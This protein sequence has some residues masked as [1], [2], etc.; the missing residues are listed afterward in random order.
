MYKLTG[1]FFSALIM[2]LPLS[3]CGEKKFFGD[4]LPASKPQIVE[5]KENVF[6]LFKD[7][8]QNTEIAVNKYIWVATLEVLNFLPIISA[9]PF[10]GVISFG[11]GKV[12]GSNLKYKGTVL[13]NDPALDARSLKVSLITKDGSLVNPK[14]IRKVENSILNRARQIYQEQGKL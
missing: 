6:D 8:D 4:L 11:L 7:K 5:K 12:P 9:D 3:G 13:I 2:V 10:T 14:T 1:F